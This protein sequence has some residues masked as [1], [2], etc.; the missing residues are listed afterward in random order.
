MKKGLKRVSA[1]IKKEIEALFRDKIALIILFLLPLVVIV[2]IGLP[3]YNKFP[4]RYLPDDFKAWMNQDWVYL[5]AIDADT[6]DGDPEYDLSQEFINILA[7]IDTPFT[8][9]LQTPDTFSALYLDVFLVRKGLAHGIV[10]VNQGFEN[11]IWSGAFGNMSI[12]YDVVD[13]KASVLVTDR[14]TKAITDFKTKFGFYRFEIIP[15]FDILDV[16]GVVPSD[17]SPIFNAA[18]MSIVIVIIASMLMLATQSI[19]S[20]VALG[21]MLLTPARKGEVIMSKLIAYLLIGSI[22]VAF[23]LSIAM[24]IFSLIVLANFLIVFILLFLISLVS[25]TMGLFLSSLSTSRLQANQYFVF[26]FVTMIILTWFLDNPELQTWVPF[27]AG[28]K[29]FTSLCYRDVVDTQ[30]FMSLGIVSLFFLIAALI[31]FQFRKRM[32]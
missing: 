10:I 30:Y 23:V 4:D 17:L 16:A 8:V 21:R 12:Y 3:N 2:A 27:Y 13:T 24:I 9:V 18:P 5:I 14:V 7:Q 20:D 26:S 11:G 28:Q 1:L 15:N 32:V 6:S 29:A 25:T 31:V 19:V 22:Q